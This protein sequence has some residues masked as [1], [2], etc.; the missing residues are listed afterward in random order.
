MYWPLVATANRYVV[1]V[2]SSEKRTKDDIS[3][4]KFTLACEFSLDLKLIFDGSGVEHES[5]CLGI[6]S[7]N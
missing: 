1:K 4:A 6:D 5:A 2:L 3:P 7:S